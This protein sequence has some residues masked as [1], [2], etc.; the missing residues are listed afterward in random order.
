[1]SWLVVPNR[2]IEMLEKGDAERSKR[3][4]AVM[5]QTRKLDIAALQRAY[6]NS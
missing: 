2:L 4:V 3:A 1:V 6:D 5:L